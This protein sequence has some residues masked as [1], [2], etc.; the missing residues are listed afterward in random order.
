MQANNH[1]DFD[2]YLLRLLE[3]DDLLPYF[4]M[5]EKNRKRLE[6]F[7]TGTVSRTKTL[8]DT[9]QFII[10]ILERAAARTYFPYLLIDKGSSAIVGFFDIKNIDWSLPKAELGCYMDEASAG[11]GIAGRAL[12][13]FVHH[14]FS[15]YGFVK[16]FLRTHESNTAAR[17]IAEKC[18]F[19][20][21]GRLRSDYRTS[22]GE[23]VDLLY[24]GLL[25]SDPYPKPS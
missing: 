5:V 17:Q 10:D 15:Q 4:Q 21:E 22:S 8:E 23:L 13:L 16:L 9:R 7:F 2:Q 6:N 3:P 1:I 12:A 20:R 18:G 11:K 14:C 25:N 19:V 24:Y